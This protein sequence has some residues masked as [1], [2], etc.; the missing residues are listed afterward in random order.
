MQIAAVIIGIALILV[1]LWDA[2]ETVVLPRRVTRRLRLVRAFYRLTWPLW[3]G[4]VHALSSRRRQENEPSEGQVLCYGVGHLRV[5]SY[6]YHVS[7]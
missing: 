6:D 7:L 5:P 3:S 1:V 4:A 2:F